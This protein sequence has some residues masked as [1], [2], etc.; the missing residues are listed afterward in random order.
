M[1]KLRGCIL[2]ESF[3]GW[4]GGKRLLRSEIVKR[5]PE[6]IGRYIEV[7]GGAAWVLFYKERYA[8]T[9]VYNDVNGDLVNLFRCVK[10]HAPEV[11]RQLAFILD[12][13]ELFEDYKSQY[14]AQGLTDIQRAARF[15]LLLKI[16]Y[17]SN[18]RN[19]GCVKRDINAMIQQLNGIQKRL[20]K[21]II[22]KKDFEDIIK[23]YDKPD[24]LFYVDP[25]YYGSEGYY[26]N[27]FT[28][29]DHIRL[30]EVLKNVKGKFLLSYNDCD[31][32]RGLYQ[33]FN[34]DEVSRQDNLR[35]RYDDKSHIY[36]EL[37]IKNY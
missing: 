28:Q 36:R 16:S 21:V 37:L 30:N 12:S 9:E 22:E 35:S 10:Y 18:G 5:F 8:E 6:K 27:K 24:S 29:Q 34:I 32:V 11:Q 4:I 14:Q 19:Y 26:Q 20:S 15:F 25:P 2:L 31:L 23:V 17:G 33:G 3:I 13:R 1:I 7:C